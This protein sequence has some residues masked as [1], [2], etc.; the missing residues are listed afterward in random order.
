MKKR[1]TTL[2]IFIVII[3][4]SLYFG[5]PRLHNFT[6]VDEPYWSY[7]RVPKFWTSV[8]T[9]KW[10]GTN[11]SD[12]PGATL[13]I[14]SGAGL[15]LVG[16]NPKNYQ[17]IRYE[18]KTPGQMQRIRDIYYDLRLPVF[19]FTLLMLPVFYLL[20]R[21]L[22]GTRVARFS[23]IFI[24]LSPV[25]LGISLIINSDAMLWILTA[26]S[27]L[28]LFVFL[29]TNE[30]KYLLLSGFFL[31][32][33]VIT[34]YV[35]NVLFVYFF[36]ILM[37]EYIFHAHK[38]Q[39]IGEYLKGAFLNFLIL[40]GMTMITAFVFFPAAWVKLSV[41][42]N[43]TVTNPVF[44]STLP[45]FAGI[46]VL[47]GIDT[48]LLNNK[49]SGL[50]FNFL[51]K[52]KSIL[53]K[54]ISAVF[55]VSVTVVFL[56]VFFQVKIYNIEALISA[57]KGITPTQNLDATDAS[58]KKIISS[59]AKENIITKITLLY[60]GAI[61]S[62][63]YELLFSISP[64]VLIFLLSAVILVGRKKEWDRDTT[65]VIYIITFILIFYLGSTVDN[66]IT[67]VRYQIMVYP[68]AFVAAAIGMAQILDSA[69]IK[70]NIPVSA[71]YTVSIILLFASLYFINPYFLAYASEA[72]PHNQIVNFKGMGEGSFEAANY[73]N[74]LPGA[75]GM[76]IW[77]D[78][79]AVCEA[80]VGR[81][82]ID[83]KQKTFETNKID[84]FVVSTDR[85]SRSLKMSGSVQ[86]LA[87]FKKAY[88]NQVYA[89]NVTI[90]GRQVNYVN[91]IKGEDILKTQPLVPAPTVPA[92]N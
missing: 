40:L 33:S 20:L 71:V 5:L 16:E 10:S 92:S 3:I 15:P 22:L 43:A 46:I 58:V 69:K 39:K 72:L 8:A 25:L 4:S 48:L 19:L 17:S 1:I 53:A 13:A 57:P 68:L 6:G 44:S 42:L 12:K 23:L 76:T 30:K 28:S 54:T 50:L 77:S 90:G 14:V 84:Y 62:D 31:G 55:L 56:H 37:M 18:A 75:S 78:K 52:Y 66:V 26:L 74:S 85:K 87:D 86:K 60:P 82:Y 49:F 51:V 21:K 61:V 35:A 70:K 32:L 24:G 79:G 59:S 83:F 63:I 89:F 41:L 80:F 11:V 81:C 88:S 34:K 36:L 64:L 45:L 7:G 67:T 2:L 47:L 65:T 38:T 29:K 9:H 91:V 73:L 27:T